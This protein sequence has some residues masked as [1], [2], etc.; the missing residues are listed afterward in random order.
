MSHIIAFVKVRTACTNSASFPLSINPVP[1][2]LPVEG[3]SP[4]EVRRVP[5][6]IMVPPLVMVPAF[7]IVMRTSTPPRLGLSGGSTAAV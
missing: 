7:P 5:P 1:S 4:I 3:V 2:A 6:L